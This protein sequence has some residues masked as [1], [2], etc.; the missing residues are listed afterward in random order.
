[1]IQNPQK[2]RYLK[3]GSCSRKLSSN[4]LQKWCKSDIFVLRLAIL[5]NRKKCFNF[6]PNKKCSFIFKN[7]EI[8][9]NVTDYP[10]QLD[11]HYWLPSRVSCTLLVELDSIAK[12][13][14]V[15]KCQKPLE[16][17]FLELTCVCNSKMHRWNCLWIQYFPWSVVTGHRNPFSQTTILFSNL[18]VTRATK[19]WN[20]NKIHIKKCS[21]F[22][23]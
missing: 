12:S 11:R 10:A 18:P 5:T 19:M 9:K 3:S 13:Q 6:F 4:P 2:S 16:P 1:M 7:F 8:L 14:R 17:C 15:R 21:K 20:E 23:G 22:L